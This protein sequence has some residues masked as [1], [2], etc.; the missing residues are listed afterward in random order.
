MTGQNIKQV[1]VLR[2]DLRNQ[3]G[4]KVMTGKLIA[5]SCH[6]SIAFLTNRLRSGIE[7]NKQISI[8]KEFTEPELEWMK[9]LFTKI[10]LKVNSEQELLDIYNR[11]KENNLEVHLIKDAGLTEFGGN[12]TLTCLAIGPDYS[13]AIDKIT[14]HLSLF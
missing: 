6:A 8:S 10:C 11:A 12:P 2:S 9:G 7:G 5:Q 3:Q 1:I 14:S 4:K 13:E